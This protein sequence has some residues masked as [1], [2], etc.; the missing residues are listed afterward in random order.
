MS[1]MLR[2]RTVLAGVGVLVVLVLQSTAVPGAFIIDECNYLSTVAGMRRGTLFVPGTAGLPASKALHAFDPAVA[3]LRTPRTPVPPRLPP[4]Y[5]G[6]ALPFSVLGWPGLVLMNVLG[7]AATALLVYAV[8]KHLGGSEVVGATAG[9]LWLL[10][11]Y[12]VEYAQGVWPQT[13]SMALFLG[14]LALAGLTAER[15]QARLPFLAGVLLATA[16]G[17]RYQCAIGLPSAAL[18]VLLWAR[19]RRRAGLLYLAGAAGPLLL[20]S[21]INHVRIGGGNPISK[22]PGYV[23]VQ[24]GRHF[25]HAYEIAMTLWSRIVDYASLPPLPGKAFSF[26][27]R[28]PS[29]EWVALGVMKKAL[30]QSS[31]WMAVGLVALG[32]AFT[33]WAPPDERAR[34]GLRMLA[35]PVAAVLAVFALAGIF[36]HDGLAFNQRYL[37]DLGPLAAV[38]TA[39]VLGGLPRRRLALVLAAAAGL[40]AALAS[41]AFVAPPLSFHLQRWLP[42]ALAASAVGLWLWQRRGASP[43]LPAAAA[44]AACLGWSATVH[45]AADLPASHRLRTLHALAWERFEPII[46]AQSPTALVVNGGNKDAICPLILEHDLVVVDA[47]LDEPAALAGLLSS[48]SDKRRVLVWLDGLPPARAAALVDGFHATTVPVEPFRVLELTR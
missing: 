8:A 37:L 5:A 14:G 16:A 2:P 46:A 33:R 32:L 22:G 39:L 45:L 21:Y 10:G 3:K 30:L 20:A 36:R 9:L 25:G 42:I 47:A 24:A 11:G 43:A 13:S 23:A 6:V 34:R 19:R 18:I 17:F 27:Q 40:L 26:M 7:F 4:L 12:A 44:L 29:G 35:V 48:L 31:P 28:L 38:A 41:L 1:R 15:D